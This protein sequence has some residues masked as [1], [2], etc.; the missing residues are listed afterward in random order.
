MARRRRRKFMRV[1]AEFKEAAGNGFRYLFTRALL[2]ALLAGV[3]WYGGTRVEAYIQE[4]SYFKVKEVQVLLCFDRSENVRWPREAVD[5]T[6]AVFVEDLQTLVRRTYKERIGDLNL[7]SLRADFLKQHPAV[8][9]AKLQKRLPDTLV[10]EVWPRTAV[11]HVDLGNLYPVDREGYLLPIVQ[12]PRDQDL[13]VVLGVKGPSKPRAGA[14]IKS[15]ALDRSLSLL[16]QAREV[17][18][19]KDY[20]VVS[21]DVHR[22]NNASLT[23]DTGLEIRIGRES[24]EEKSGDLEVVLSNLQ[25][26]EVLPQYVDLRFDDAVVGLR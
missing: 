22:L 5:K 17:A 8:K 2:I 20:E 21:V 23:L 6:V 9:N 11:A 18:V 26:Q 7:A 16:E 25:D 15:R 24:L 14:Q 12:D 19:L 1:S 3:F 10:L 13:P 4:S